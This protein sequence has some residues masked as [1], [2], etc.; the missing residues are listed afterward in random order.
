[1]D[2]RVHR[3]VTLLIASK[4]NLAWLRKGNEAGFNGTPEFPIR[5]KC[6]ED[7][8]ISVNTGWKYQSIIDFLWNY[9]AIL[10]HISE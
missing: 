6:V 7:S 5:L 2:V 1:M 4:A 9:T 10:S 8:P 3:G